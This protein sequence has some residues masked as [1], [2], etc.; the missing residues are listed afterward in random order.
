MYWIPPIYRAGLWTARTV[1]IFGALE[2]MIDL[3]NFVHGTDWEQC[4]A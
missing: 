2:T 1:G 3:R 4:R